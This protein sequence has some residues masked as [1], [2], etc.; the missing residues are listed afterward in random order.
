M[1]HMNFLETVVNNDIDSL[2]Q[3]ESTYKGSWKKRGGVGAYMMMARKWDRIEGMMEERG[4]DVFKMIESQKAAR[5]KDGTIIAE[6]RDLRRYLL[7]IE[8]EM[9]ARGGIFIE[10]PKTM[11][12]ANRPGTSEDGGHHSQQPTEGQ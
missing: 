4:Y 5:G 2:I 10:E 3:K 1:D 8:A 12:E 9:I 11:K 7:L 6:I